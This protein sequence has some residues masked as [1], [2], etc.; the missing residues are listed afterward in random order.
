M[1]LDPEYNDFEYPVLG[2]DGEYE[3]MPYRKRFRRFV[4]IVGSKKVYWKEFWDPRQIDAR[5][6]KAAR[7]GEAVVLANEMIH[8]KVYS[9]G[10]PYGLPRWAGVLLSVVG[11]RAAEEINY[12][13]FD[14]KSVPPLVCWVR[15]ALAEG[16]ARRLRPTSR[17]R[18][19]A[20]RTS[21]RCCDQDRVRARRVSSSHCGE[22]SAK[23]DLKPLPNLIQK[24]PCS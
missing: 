4:Q 3:M 12:Q 13:Y 9:T 21:T 11:S 5:T 2:V 20:A 22:A 10:S 19:R 1:R 14:N 15:R 17:S 8:W 6:G 16:R 23:V 7:D 18:S 24:E